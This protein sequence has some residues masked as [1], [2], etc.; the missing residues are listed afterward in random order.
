MNNNYDLLT[1]TSSASASSSSSN[2]TTNE[3]KFI[4]SKSNSLKDL[5]KF[6]IMSILHQ[7]IEY[8]MSLAKDATGSRVLEQFFETDAA[9]QT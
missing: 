3:P 1:I 2:S 4:P 7:S 5:S 8:L 6:I 9:N